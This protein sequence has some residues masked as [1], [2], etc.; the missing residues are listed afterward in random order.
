M[1]AL[2]RGITSKHNGG[3]YCLNCF[4]SFRTADALKKHKNVGKDHDYY[5]LEMPDKDNNADLES[6]PE[7]MSTCHNDPVKSSTTEINK[8]ILSGFSVF[9]HCS[10]DTTKNKLDYYRG[11]DC[12]K[13]FCK[14][15]KKHAEKI[16]YWEKRK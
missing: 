1:S 11:E 4:Y 5:Y 16:I 9:T 8:H 6:F 12:M 2:L 14:T 13:E 7:K 10:F 15:L 3:F